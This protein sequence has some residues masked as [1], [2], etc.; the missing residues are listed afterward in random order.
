MTKIYQ[1]SH[2]AG[3]NAGFT[4]IELLVVVLIIGILAAVALPRYEIAVE[5]SR[6]AAL[7]PLGRAVRDAQDAYYMANG[8]YTNNPEELDIKVDC[9]DKYECDFSTS[10]KESK[11]TIYPSSAQNFSSAGYG[12][13]FSYA[14]RSTAEG[15]SVNYCAAKKSNEKGMRVCKS[16]GQPYLT[17]NTWIRVKIQ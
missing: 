3:K 6:L 14:T 16:F 4:L 10:E 5:K 17:D 9:P 7:V 13:V 12:L 11:F 15:A 2:P 1:N 8:K